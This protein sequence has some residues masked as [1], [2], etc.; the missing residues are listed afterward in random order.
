VER[1]ADAAER[2][3]GWQGPEGQSADLADQRQEL[4]DAVAAGS[5]GGKV[6]HTAVAPLTSLRRGTVV[7]VK[8]PGGPAFV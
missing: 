4:G 8:T 3:G 7:E 6:V 5:C 1:V 2:L